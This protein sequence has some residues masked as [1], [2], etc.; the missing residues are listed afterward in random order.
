M[1]TEIH[2]LISIFNQFD[3]TVASSYWGWQIAN[4]QTNGSYAHSQSFPSGGDWIVDLTNAD[5][6]FR[7][8][9]DAAPIPEPTTMLLLGTGLVGVAGAARRRK[10]NQ[11]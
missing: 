1:N 6:A 3:P 7:L 11:T 4:T 2:R 5:L 8:T 9:D 10:K